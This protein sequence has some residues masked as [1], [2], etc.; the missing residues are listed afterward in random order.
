MERRNFLK[1]GAAGLAAA[2]AATNKRYRAGVIGHTGRG[3]YGH[4]WDTAWNGFEAVQVVAVADPNDAG[5]AA[6]MKRCGAASGYRDYREMLR[7]E[8]PDLV[9]IGPR[10]LDQRV[11]MVTAAAQAGA[12]ILLEKPFAASLADADA[13]VEAVEKNKVRL[14][15][16][17]QMRTSPSVRRV[18]EMVRGGEI[19]MVQ[20]VRGRGKE[21][22]RAGGEDLMVLGVHIFDVMRIVLGDP[23]WVFAHVTQDGGGIRRTNVRQASEPI[24]PV[25]GNQ[26][27]AMFAFDG[28]VHGYFGSKANQRT[29]P[30]RFGYYFFGSEGVIYMPNALDSDPYILRSP[31]WM[32][33]EQH[34][35]EKI[36]APADADAKITGIERGHANAR[37]VR[38]LL[39]AIDQKRDPVC[40]ARDG[41]WTVEMV[42]SIYQSQ[43]TGARV[44]FPLKDRRH[45]LEL[46]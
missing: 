31:A 10:W 25:A 4:G 38:D 21:D 5:R 22:S 43:R 40:S 13:M 23:R 41:R 1:F 26:V 34:R 20:E 33:D 16:G 44:E 3:D 28:G 27:A 39:E 14:Q 2:H 30:K 29:H 46:L 42:L 8:K 15:V 45:P 36:E 9:S 6:A 35:W 18:R 7:K 37:M 19:G 24:G 32:P 17:H 12:H 11:E